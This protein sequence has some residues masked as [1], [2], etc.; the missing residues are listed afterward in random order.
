[1]TSFSF[2]RR[3]LVASVFFAAL[4]PV[5]SAQRAGGSSGFCCIPEVG[6]SSC[7]GA[8]DYVFPDEF[9]CFA[10]NT[11]PSDPSAGTY[12][13]TEEGMS[14][15]PEGEAFDTSYSQCSYFCGLEHD[16]WYCINRDR[17]VADPAICIPKSTLSPDGVPIVD[18]ALSDKE[19]GYL[20]EQDCLD[21]CVPVANTCEGCAQ[22]AAI[23]KKSGTAFTQ[24]FCEQNTKCVWEVAAGGGGSCKSKPECARQ[25]KACCDVTNFSVMIG[26][27]DGPDLITQDVARYTTPFITDPLSRQEIPNPEFRPN[28]NWQ[29]GFAGWAKVGMCPG[30]RVLNSPKDI[31]AA[32]DQCKPQYLACC[33][34]KAKRVYVTELAQGSGEPPSLTPLLDWFFP[35]MDYVRD[36]ADPENDFF[37]CVADPDSR[38]WPEDPA[39]VSVLNVDAITDLYTFTLA[40]GVTEPTPDPNKPLTCDSCRTCNG[41]ACFGREAKNNCES[42]PRCKFTEIVGQEQTI[43]LCHARLEHPDCRDIPLA[44]NDCFFTF[45]NKDSCN[46]APNN[47]CL[48]DDKAGFCGQNPAVCKTTT[49]SQKPQ[50]RQFN[51]CNRTINRPLPQGKM[52]FKYDPALEK[53]ALPSGSTVIKEK[54]LTTHTITFGDITDCSDKCSAITKLA[55]C[56]DKASRQCIFSDRDQCVVNKNITYGVKDDGSPNGNCAADCAMF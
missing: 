13:A 10:N 17:D 52:C 3:A 29:G 35:A 41:K 23:A 45:T 7:L 11:N 5:V 18:K 21:A 56:C 9:S 32:A 16:F 44:C 22:M 31:P 51:A 25:Y 37:A 19:R 55:Y 49:T 1:M 38:W 26:A 28:L 24:Q 8:P 14:K 34:P 2:S 6:G 39:G 30:V 54:L 53:V 48:W 4:V 43:T 27:S 12:I 20:R 46:A 33:D 50:A 42:N 47:T 36:N 40:C 15:A